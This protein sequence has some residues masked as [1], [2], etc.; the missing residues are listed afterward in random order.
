MH[1]YRQA[2]ID[3]GAV[4]DPGLVRLGAH[5]PGVAAELAGRAAG[6]AGP[7]HRDL[8]RIG[9]A[10]HGRAVRRR[11]A[12]R[13]RAGEL[14][15]IGFDDIEAAALLHLSTVHQPLER[16]GAEG[17]RRLCALLR[18]SRCGRC[19][20]S[21]RSGSCNARARAASASPPV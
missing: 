19:G 20:S 10:G 18:G 2:L 14:S 8:R 12:R 13:R 3:S 6:P 1:G 17:A 4:A 16:S 9:R 15:V 21:S 11:A 5:G 7:A